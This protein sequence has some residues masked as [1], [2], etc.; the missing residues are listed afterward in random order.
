MKIPEEFLKFTIY[1]HQDVDE[2]YSTGEELVQDAL[3]QLTPREREV[4]KNYLDEL[5]SGK[6]DEMQLREI[7]RNTR[8]DISPFRGDEGSCKGFLEYIRSM[9]SD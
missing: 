9:I 5:V 7:W 3:D 1:F 8:A 6:Y 4:V 2:I